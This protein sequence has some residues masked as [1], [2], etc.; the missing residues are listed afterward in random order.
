M[1]LPSEVQEYHGFLMTLDPV[2]IGTGSYR[3]GRVDLPILREPATN[4][5]KIPGTSLNGMARAY[6]ALVVHGTRRQ[7]AGQGNDHCGSKDC[8]VC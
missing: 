7:C 3:L 4:L 5:P 8:A 2:H 6:A 1:P